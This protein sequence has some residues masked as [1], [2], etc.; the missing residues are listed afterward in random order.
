MEF[1]SIAIVHICGFMIDISPPKRWGRRKM[2]G[3]FLTGGGIA[4]LSVAVIQ[5]LGQYSIENIKSRN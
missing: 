5:W 2:H 4:C 3:S 1:S